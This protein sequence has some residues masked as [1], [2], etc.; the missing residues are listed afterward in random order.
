MHSQPRTGMQLSLDN[1]LNRNSDLLDNGSSGGS[2]HTIETLKAVNQSVCSSPFCALVPCCQTGR[3][4]IQ[5]HT[6]ARCVKNPVSN[7]IK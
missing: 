4:L 3:P 6:A 1:W 7:Q 5:L 2:C